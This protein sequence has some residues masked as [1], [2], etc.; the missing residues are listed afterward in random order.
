M[1]RMMHDAG[2]STSEMG[3]A[4]FCASV[5]LGF[6]AVCVIEDHLSGHPVISMVMATGRL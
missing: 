5:I 3:S 2:V 6:G 4:S 1:Q